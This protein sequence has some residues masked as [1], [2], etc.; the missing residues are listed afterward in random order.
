MKE[1][2]TLQQWF[3]EIPEPYRTQAIANIPD[4]RK[5][6][7]YHSLADAVV[8]GFL[9]VDSPQGDEYWDEFWK[10]LNS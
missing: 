2:K 1:P 10:S 8:M 4:K 6:Q 5:T 3:E 9:W 7:T